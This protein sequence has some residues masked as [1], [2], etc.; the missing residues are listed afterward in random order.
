[1]APGA[2]CLVRV[3]HGNL[4]RVVSHALRHEPWVYE[5]E[6]DE[7]GWVPI[8]ELVESLQVEP[9]WGAL[10]VAD[11]EA[12]VAGASKERHEVQNGRIRALYGHSMPGRIQR[13]AG[14]P[15]HSLFH[16]TSPAAAEAILVDGLLPMGRQFV[17]L[18]V[19]RGMA[20]AVGAR[21]AEAP[22]VLR[23]DARAAVNAGVRFYAGNEKVWLADLVPS[24]FISEDAR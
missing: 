13:V 4:S 11:V 19:D 7:Q 23:V 9:G 17:H 22:V 12:M 18:S 6:L 14:E 1:M 16:G 15:P 20:V 2:G 24:N 5:L 8:T 21:K 10:T 3:H